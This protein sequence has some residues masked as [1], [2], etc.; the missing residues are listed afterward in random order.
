MNAFNIP[1]SIFDPN[2]SIPSCT[3]AKTTEISFES[4]T[5]SSWSHTVTHDICMIHIN[6][7]AVYGVYGNT[8][9]YD[10][11]IT[12]LKDSDLDTIYLLA[13]NATIVKS[14]ATITIRNTNIGNVGSAIIT[15]Y[16]FD[17]A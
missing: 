11:S 1:Y 7:S 3:F 2:Q 6:A 5:G 16:E 17:F 8:L 12:C 4:S 14:G 13:P 15:I 9:R 10:C